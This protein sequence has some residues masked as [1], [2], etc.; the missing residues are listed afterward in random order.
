MKK[1]LVFILTAVTNYPFS[2]ADEAAKQTREEGEGEGRVNT[3]NGPENSGH[4]SVRRQGVYSNLVR[5]QEH[6]ALDCR[7]PHSFIW[8]L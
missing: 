6:T 1:L 3:Y 7:V 2:W 5:T 4:G 8:Q